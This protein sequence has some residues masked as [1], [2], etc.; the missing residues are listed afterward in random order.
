MSAAE[1]IEFFESKIRPVLVRE[2]YGCHSKNSGKAR[3]GLQ[4][5]TKMGALLGGDSGPAIVPG[6]LE[7]S[8]LW[9]AINYEDFSMPPSKQLSHDIIGDFAAWIEMGAPDPRGQEKMQANATVTAKDI[10]QGKQFWSFQKPTKPSVPDVQNGQWSEHPIDR[11]VLQKLEANDLEPAA[12]ADPHTL[13]RRLCFDLIGLPPT[14]EQIQWFLSQ[15]HQDPDQAVVQ[16]VDFLLDSERFGERWGRHWLDVARYAESSGK[17]INATFPH[18]WR[19]RDYVIDAFNQDKPYDQFLR[20]QIAGDLLPVKTDEDWTE[21]LIA[22]GFLAIGP[23]TL[24]EQNPRQFSMDLIDEQIDVATRVVLGISVACARCHDHKFDP[25]PQ[26]DYYAMAGIFTSTNTYYGTLDTQQNRRPSRLIELPID[27]PNSFDRSLSESEIQQLKEQLE[28][29]A[30]EFQELLQSRRQARRNPESQVNPQ[31]LFRQVA[32]VR[33]QMAALESVLESHDEQGQP[34]SFCMGV[35]PA[36]RPVNAHLLVRGEIDQPAQEISRGFVQV[37]SGGP[38]KV[39]ENSTGRLELARWMTSDQNPLTARVMVNRIWQ[40]LLGQGIVETTENFG[41]TGQPPSHP[42][43][44]DYLAVSFMESDWSIK[45]LIRQVATSRT[46][47]MS[48]QFDAESFDVDPDNRWLWRASPRRLDAEVLRDAM[49]SISDQLTTER[50][51][52]SNVAKGGETVVRNG[53]LRNTADLVLAGSMM[54]RD[55]RRPM[56]DA[57]SDQM[58]RRRDFRRRAAARTGRP[59]V[60]AI[61]LDPMTD[62]RSVYLPIVRDNIPRSLAV[63]DFAESSM[64]VGQRETSNTPDQGLYFMNNE[65]VIRQSD[66]FAQRLLDHS[67]QVSE[68]IEQAFLLAYGRPGTER[69]QAAARDFYD[70][71]E[72]GGNDEAAEKLRCLCQAIMA[73]AEFRILN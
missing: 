18:A 2:C 57:N 27:D 8:P 61:S 50:P 17:E 1:G 37:I 73:A 56:A 16:A 15:W 4:L 7:D 22:T 64:V 62:Y 10:K 29:K 42:A 48:S 40:H 13:L 70:S 28:Q 34:R 52:A 20:E 30:A 66:L 58:D 63:F 47:R 45:S 11:F 26:S 12:D 33:T 51:R 49:L 41:S 21:N 36:D 35:Q 60:T 39:R 53:N 46:Y 9:S 54:A 25:I 3:G 31:N 19:Y 67:S 69:E 68:Q 59:N 44:L 24:T 6:S 65:F 23:K 72:T 32:V 55:D 71:F 43:L 38:I 5:D 14:G